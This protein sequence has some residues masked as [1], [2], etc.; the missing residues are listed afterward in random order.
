MNIVDK[1]MDCV[2]VGDRERGVHFFIQWNKENLGNII[3]LEI[4]EE[5]LER[6]GT[7][8]RKSKLSLAQVFIATKIVEDILDSDLQYPLVNEKKSHNVVK[9]PI[10]IGNIEDDFHGLGRKIVIAFLK[11]SNWEIID[12]GNDTSPKEFVDAAIKSKS[13]IIAISAMMYTTA[14]NIKKIREILNERKLSGKIKVVVG[15]AVFRLRPELVEEVGADGTCSTAMNAPYY[16]LKL[17]N[18]IDEKDV[19]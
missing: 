11:A 6:L 3:D 2:K 1:M 13:K 17:M 7:D 8:W 9:S 18:S 14:C 12:L 10:V 15:G 4:I 16:F 5:F 19:N